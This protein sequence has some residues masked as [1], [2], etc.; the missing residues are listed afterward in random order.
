MDYRN[1]TMRGMGAA[2]LR[3]VFLV[4]LCFYASLGHAAT[5]TPQ[6][7]TGNGTDQTAQVAALLSHDGYYLFKG[8]VK[9]GPIVVTGK[10]VT[11]DFDTSAILKPDHKIDVLWN[12]VD[13][14][15]EILHLNVDGNGLAQTAVK[16]V[17]GTLTAQ[18]ITMT[19]VGYPQDTATNI[20]TGLWLHGTTS[21]TI[22]RAVFTNFHSIG[23]G[24][25]GNGVGAVRGI[26]LEQTGLVNITRFEMSGGDAKEDNDYF[27]AQLGTKGGT[28]GQ[29]IARYNGYT[30]RVFK[31]QSGDWKLSDVNIAAGPDFVTD[32]RATQVGSYNL[33][34]IDFATNGAGSITI[35]S[36]KLNCQGF[37]VCISESGGTAHVTTGPGVTLQGSTLPVIRLN[38]ETN[39]QQNQAS[40]GFYSSPADVGSGINGS[41]II[42][43]GTG[44]ILLGMN[45]FVTNAKFIDPVT[46]ATQI[47]LKNPIS[48]I[49]FNGNTV[50]TKTLGYVNGPNIVNIRYATSPSV[51][52]NQLIEGGNIMHSKHF[53]TLISASNVTA[54]G[55]I[56]PVGTLPLTP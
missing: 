27:H 44:A 21:A 51:Q 30:R 55:N 12:F 17:N 50:T 45:S 49:V 47:G 14:N 46:L 5:G 54:S 4:F 37:P 19:N 26:Y 32:S 53:I 40:I 39:V 6:V 22:G 35:V 42:N 9:T 52:N 28:I 33:N 20:V 11:I 16:V 29:L 7:F 48:G 24:V 8:T 3:P 13:S 1:Q 34:A 43:F 38:R 15:V 25:Y 31:A 41:T 2:M 23:D 18:A 56:A 10:H 36:G